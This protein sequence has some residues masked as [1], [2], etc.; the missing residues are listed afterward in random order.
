MNV[1]NAMFRV[2]LSM[3][4]PGLCVTVFCFFLGQGYPTHYIPTICS[5]Q[6]TQQEFLRSPF[7]MESWLLNGKSSF[8]LP[9]PIFP[10]V[11]QHILTIHNLSN[12]VASLPDLSSLQ[13][14][15]SMQ[16]CLYLPSY[17]YR[18]R[19]LYHYILF[20]KNSQQS[21]RAYVSYIYLSN[22][23]WDHFMHLVKQAILAMKIYNTYLKS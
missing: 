19:F 5:F 7:T 13:G 22:T 17:N 20:Q 23:F 9:I 12:P 1:G 15:K 10:I 18:E 11:I 6:A 14:R 8:I 16:I 2:E 4:F 21:P 3:P